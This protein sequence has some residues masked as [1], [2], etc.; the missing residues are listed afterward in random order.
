VAATSQNEAKARSRDAHRQEVRPFRG[1]GTDCGPC[2]AASR[3]LGLIPRHDSIRDEQRKPGGGTS[4]TTPTFR[5]RVARTS[6]NV[7][8]YLVVISLH[9]KGIRIERGSVRIK[10]SHLRGSLQLKRS[11]FHGKEGYGRTRFVEIDVPILPLCYNAVYDS[12]AFIGR[13]GQST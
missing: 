1:R 7:N 8:N 3:R 9:K 11:I 6:Y 13:F 10:R 12:P 4:A 5:W 2:L